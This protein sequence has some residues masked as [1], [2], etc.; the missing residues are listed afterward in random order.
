[1]TGIEAG[2]AGGF[3]PW[4]WRGGDPLEARRRELFTMA[5]PVFRRHGYRGATVKALAHACGLRPASLY[6]YFRSKEDLATCLLRGPRLDWDSTW[7]NPATDP[8]AQLRVLVD[9]SVS[10]LQTYL[11]ALRLADEIAGAPTQDGA[12]VQA[13]REG[14]GVF[15]RMLSAAAPGMARPDAERAARDVLAALV[16][17]A[18]VNLD[19]EPATETRARVVAILRSALVPMHVDGGRYD[20]TMGSAEQKA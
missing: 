14:E 13:F 17:S 2:D 20:A 18:I 11:L 15:G 9:V 8:L 7:V 3:Q 10:E 6:H 5:A 1:V 16:G 4:R 12:H 19:L